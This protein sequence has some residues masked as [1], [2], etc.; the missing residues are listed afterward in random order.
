MNPL[1]KNKIKLLT[2]LKLKKY[3]DEYNLFI[4]EGKKTVSDIIHN[5]RQKIRMIVATKEWL[6]K[7]S[8][9]ID[10]NIDVFIASE[11]EMKSVSNLTT[12]AEVMAVIKIPEYPA[13]IERFSHNLSIMLDQ[14]RDPGNLGT[15]IRI[16]NWYG[17]ENIICSEDTVDCFNPKV[18]QAS[19]GS[20]MNVK[21]HYRNLTSFLSDIK[22][23]FQLPVY[24]ASIGGTSIYRQEFP[25]NAIM[26]FG[27]ESKG[28]S[29]NLNEYIDVHLKIPPVYKN[30]PPVD[31]LNVSIAVAIFGYEFRR[32]YDDK[33]I[34]S[35]EK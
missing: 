25:E 21:I 2:S 6:N 9:L 1:S 4:A 23:R 24:G 10:Q 3:R 34:Q 15:I 33:I 32:K 30:L 5:H 29:D 17:I 8:E 18:V 13:D 22:T 27:N 14:V 35:E 31:S 7:Q 28:I 19:M 20:V 26:I 11:K 16:A 12:V